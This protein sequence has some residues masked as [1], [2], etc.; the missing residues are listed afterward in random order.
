ML[1]EREGCIKE[2][3]G[4]PPMCET[5]EESYQTVPLLF[6]YRTKLPEKSR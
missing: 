1:G 2:M 3:K 5:E 4:S 6:C